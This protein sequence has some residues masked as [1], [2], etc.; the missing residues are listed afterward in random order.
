MLRDY[1]EKYIRIG[2]LIAELK[3]CFYF[4]DK[5]AAR[6]EKEKAVL[7]EDELTALKDV[8][9]Q[10]INRCEALDMPQAQELLSHAYDDPPK[11]EREFSLLVR[12]VTGELK[13]RLFL[14]VPHHQAKFYEN[15]QLVS[16]QVLGAF[17]K[18]SEEIRLSGTSYATGL[19]S[20]CVFHA[21]RA[22]EI[23]LRALGNSI[24]LVLKNGKPI[25]LAEWREILDGLNAAVLKIENLPNNTPNKEADQHFYSEASAQ[26]R[27]FKN[28]WRVRNAHGRASYTEQ[29]ALE[30]INHVVSFF[31]I[32]A[33]RLKEQTP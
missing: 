7:T 23:G 17:P 30:V 12:A 16:E 25:E 9:K 24:N 32:L 11:T 5:A 31:E 21:M 3:A 33:A 26:F 29:Q 4:T 8:L 15:D 13:N 28:G 22:A 10:L 6:G 14:F 27:F 20:A 18:A 2:E 1:A 19:N